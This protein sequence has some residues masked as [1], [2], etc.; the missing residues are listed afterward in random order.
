M[1]HQMIIIAY[2]RYINKNPLFSV[3]FC[4][5]LSLVIAFV[6]HDYII[7]FNNYKGRLKLKRGI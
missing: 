7:R 2:S 3:A 5:L 4:L 6:V 1:I